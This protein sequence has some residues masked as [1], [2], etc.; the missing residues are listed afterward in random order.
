MPEDAVLLDLYRRMVVGA[1]ST[2][3]RRR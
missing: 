3:R 2:R 1:G